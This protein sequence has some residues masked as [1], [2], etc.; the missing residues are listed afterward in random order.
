MV[1][2][3]LTYGS[4]V[5][6]QVVGSWFADPSSVVLASLTRGVRG[7]RDHRLWGQSIQI[8]GKPFVGDLNLSGVRIL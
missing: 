6:H 5:L 2:G 3:R 1:I 7:L 4:V 8:L